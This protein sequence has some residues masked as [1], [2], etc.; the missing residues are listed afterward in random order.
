MH[1]WR[2]GATQ[3]VMLGVYKTY[4]KAFR[5]RERN[6]LTPRPF[7]LVFVVGSVDLPRPIYARTV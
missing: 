4:K 1:C 6:A 3:L 7:S 2:A 5:P